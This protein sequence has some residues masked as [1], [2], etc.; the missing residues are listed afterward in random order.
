MTESVE[1]ERDEILLAVL[2]HVLFDGWSQK[3]LAAGLKDSGLGESEGLGVFPGGVS[4][5]A[6]HFNNHADRQMLKEISKM[7]LDS[8]S[9]R[10]RIIAATRARLEVV[11]AHRE[12]IRR[13]LTYLSLPQNHLIGM[14][15]SLNTVDAIWYA[16]GDTSTDF[17]YYTKRGLLLGVYSATVLYWLADESEG[18]EES[19]GFLER[20]IND[21]LKL[22]K[23]GS[24]VGDRLKKGMGLM[25]RI[26][27][28]IFRP[29]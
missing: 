4:E 3:A 9:V 7:D 17:N 24:K 21:V 20:R 25:P 5:L 16:T 13:L 22:P 26:G 12:S 2:P 8:M 1:K 18:F 28:R 10:D 29:I 15:C 6:A 19:W 27:R 14:R 11:A 23:L